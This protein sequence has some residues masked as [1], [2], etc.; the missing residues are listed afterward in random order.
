[1]VQNQPSEALKA[2]QLGLDR[3]PNSAAALGGVVGV[4]V[5]ERQTDKAIATARQYVAKSPDNAGFHTLLGDLL[6]TQKKDSAAA[7][8]EYRKAIDIAKTDLGGYV[9]LALVQYDRGDVDGAL[10]TY[11][12]AIQAMPNDV[13]CY[14]RAGNI[15]EQKKDWENARLMYQKVLTIDP[16]NGYASNSLAYVMLEQGGNLDVAF[17]LAQ[18]ARRK[19][20]DSP[21]TADTL[22]FAFY[23]RRV[24]TSAIGLFQEAVRSAPE[25]ALYTYHLGMAY[26]KNGQPAQARQQL[27]RLVRINPNGS[28]ADDLRRELA[29]LRG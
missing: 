28:E 19:L 27:E 16:D 6:Q 21:N 14:F 1:M 23:Q 26:A 8:A 13:N 5:L 29:S 4:N 25:N 17:S 24:Y 20:P 7:E 3:D 2:Y 11:L 15:Y 10:K 18:N 9:G 22:G 12:N